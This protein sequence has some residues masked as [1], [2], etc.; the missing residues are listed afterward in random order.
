M[1]GSSAAR[2]A[3]THGEATPAAFLAFLPSMLRLGGSWVLIT[4]S[5]SLLMNDLE[6]F[7]GVTSTRRDRLLHGPW[8]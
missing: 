4:P 8:P 2:V 7:G 6:D 1:R 3:G 5:I